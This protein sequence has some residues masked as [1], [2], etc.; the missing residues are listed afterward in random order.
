MKKYSK[1][2]AAGVGFLCVLAGPSVFGL[3][4]VELNPET[5]MQVLAA[6]AGTGAVYQVTNEG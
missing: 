2:I 3:T 6:I 1:A 4:S 5:I